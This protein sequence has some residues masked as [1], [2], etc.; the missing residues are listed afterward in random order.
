M[1]ELLKEMKS[2]GFPVTPANDDIHCHVFED[3]SGVIEMAQVHKYHPQ[4]KHLNVILHH[5]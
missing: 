4:T 5:F 1:M 2:I 3:N